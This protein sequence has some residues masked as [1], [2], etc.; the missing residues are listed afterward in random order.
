MDLRPSGDTIADYLGDGGLRLTASCI[1]E[2]PS[3]SGCGTFGDS[4][5]GTYTV[6]LAPQQIDIGG[7]TI[8]DFFG[9]DWDLLQS[10]QNPYFGFWPW[11]PSSA[12]NFGIGDGSYDQN[13][14][15]TYEFCLLLGNECPVCMEVEVS[16]GTTPPIVIAGSPT[17]VD[18]TTLGTQ[19]V[20][21]AALGGGCC[22]SD[23]GS[24][25]DTG[26][27][28]GNPYAVGPTPTQFWWF[29]R[30]VTYGS[31]VFQDN[32]LCGSHGNTQLSSRTAM[33]LW[34]IQYKDTVLDDF[35][36][37]GGNVLFCS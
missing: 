3:G 36:Q 9:D 7:G 12:D 31:F 21:A 13:A 33:E 32:K 34:D 29:N 22:G 14:E 20:C 37:V 27:E 2:G 6:D 4:A 26:A 19:D 30:D 17:Q 28:S 5:G 11:R 1:D 18:L 35:E 16:Y 15:A 25:L 24:C 23:F 10:S 8:V